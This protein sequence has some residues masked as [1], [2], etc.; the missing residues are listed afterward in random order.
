MATRFWTVDAF[1]DRPFSGNPAAVVP[2]ERW[3]ED[4]WLQ[5]V[6]AEFAL[7]ETA[8]VV[9]EDAGEDEAPGRSYALRWY[10]PRVEVD[11]CGH[12]TLATAVALWARDGERRALGFTTRSGPLTVRPDDELTAVLDLPT[13]PTRPVDD[14][15]LGTA[16]AAALRLPDAPEAV[17]RSDG[18]QPN[19]LVAVPDAAAVRACRPD[20]AAVAALPAAGV[21]VTAAGEGEVDVVS[22][23]FMPGDGI[24]EDPVTGS[25]HCSLAPYWGARLGRD[26]LTCAQ[27][28]P[29]GGRVR[30]RLR[31][32]R[33][34][35]AGS[36][37]LVAEGVLH[38]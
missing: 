12:A 26:V 24:D 11:L 28:S 19:L 32:D 27:L 20:L 15:R 18:R 1:T 6:A 37:V 30:T 36:A 14:D 4:A 35:V 16:V 29:R 2:L 9:P 34:E 10:T 33:T 38:A 7:S 13:L 3:P 25:A 8:F 21:I 17:E 31:G 22:R 5:A 23:Y